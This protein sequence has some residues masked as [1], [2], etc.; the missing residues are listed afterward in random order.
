M[1]RTRLTNL[2]VRSALRDFL[3]TQEEARTVNSAL[4][5]A[6]TYPAVPSNRYPLQEP[7]A[8]HALWAPGAVIQLLK[9]QRNVKMEKQADYQDSTVTM[10]ASRVR[11]KNAAPKGR[12][13]KLTT[14]MCL[15]VSGAASARPAMP[16][17]IQSASATTN[18]ATPVSHVRT[19]T[20]GF[21]RT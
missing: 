6:L 16:G 21:Q 2:R 13:S 10:F 20:R 14:R 8:F 4:R 19:P 18:S 12:V 17:A 3:Q 15:T 1:L 9:F 11:G 5:L 7:S